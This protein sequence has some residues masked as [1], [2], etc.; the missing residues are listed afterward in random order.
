[1]AKDK[2]ASM[3]QVQLPTFIT[4]KEMVDFLHNILRNGTPEEFEAALIQVF[5][6]NFFV[7]GSTTQLTEQS[8]QLIAS[9]IIAAWKNKA[10]Y[11]QQ[12]CQQYQLNRSLSSKSHFYV[13]GCINNV[14]TVFGVQPFNAGYVE[15]VPQT[16]LKLTEL[17][18]GVRQDQDAI[19]FIN[20][21]SDRKKL[22]PGDD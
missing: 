3:P 13:L 17:R 9:T 14:T 20:S 7:Q 19:D 6:P 15:G 12:Y 18:V 22:C 5:S 8:K 4:P 1:M 16:K 10:T 2:L 11:K 21:F